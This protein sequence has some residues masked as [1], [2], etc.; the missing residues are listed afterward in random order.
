ML[1][2]NVPLRLGRGQNNR[3][4]HMARHRRVKAEREAVSWVLLGKPRP[5]LPC[6]VR[7][8]RIA[9]SNGMDDDGCVGALKSVRDGVASWLGVD[10]GRADLVTYVAHQ[11]RGPWGVRIEVEM[12]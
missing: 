11:E 4:H 9:P 6:V 7:M 3:E 5:P 1:I 12:R 8:V 2:V 10:D